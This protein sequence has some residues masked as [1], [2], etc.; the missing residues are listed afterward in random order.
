MDK[1]M[2]AYCGAGFA[3]KGLFLIIIAALLFFNDMYNWFSFM[4]M[5]ALIVALVGLKCLLM[6][7]KTK[8]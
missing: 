3:G 6:S 8:N 7:Q 2:H 1:D 4:Q 5:L